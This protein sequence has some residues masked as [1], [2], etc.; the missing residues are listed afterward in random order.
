MLHLE[1]GSG[2]VR[3]CGVQELPELLRPGDLLVVNNSR[4][5][6]AKLRGRTE[7]GAGV[8]LLLL[9]PEESNRW[10]VL[11]RP[12]RRLKV[13]TTVT[14]GEGELQARVSASSDFG[15][16]TVELFFEGNLYQTLEKVGR[17][18]L[19]P[20]IKRGQGAQ[21][22]RDRE[23]YQTIYAREKG[24][25]AAPTAG[26]HFTP[27]LVGA[28]EKRGVRIAELTL[29][30]GYGTFQPVRTEIVE[31]HHVAPERYAIPDS[32]VRAIERAQTE[33]GRVVAVGTTTVRAL[34][35]AARESGE[36]RGGSGVT[37]LFIY[38]GHRFRVVEA[39]L[40]NLHLPKSS[41]LLLVSAFGGV[42]PVRRAYREA[43]R[44]RYRF[45]SYG[46]CMLLC[47]GP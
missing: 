2:A 31:E 19:P 17:T 33:G 23:R 26:L 24:S 36:L 47:A 1:L 35:T 28:L 34:E 27:E 3:H 37:E 16:R 20:Y 10:E 46:D 13:G 15:K 5:F 12:A 9:Q 44:E 45:Y 25:I 14:F 41:L 11:G 22:E 43:V 39:L 7:S 18:P 32:T 38:P 6:P 8:E 30:V 21:E 42:E 29:H 4:V 40:T